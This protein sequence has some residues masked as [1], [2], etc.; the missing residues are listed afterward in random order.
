[1]KPLNM[2]IV[3]VCLVLTACA[4]DRPK[5]DILEVQP[6]HVT[7]INSEEVIQVSQQ[8]IKSELKLNFHIRNQD[9]FVESY[10]PNFSFKE[11]GGQKKNGEGYLA[12][13]V[14]GKL[15]DEIDT[16]AFVVKNLPI[17]KHVLTVEVFHNDSTTYH[18]KESFDVNITK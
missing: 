5:A 3:I 13:Y 4:K 10:I 6:L 18:L 8:N 9:V 15:I 16:A 11:K 12:V 1:M 2:I 17:G 7:D 14:D